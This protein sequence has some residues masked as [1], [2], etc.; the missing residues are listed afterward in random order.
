MTTSLLI[1]PST[2]TLWQPEITTN[3]VKFN[4]KLGF[5]PLKRGPLFASSAPISS[6]TVSSESSK[7]E[8]ELEFL[9][10]KEGDP[11]QRVRVASGEKVLRNIMLDN[12]I[13]LYAT[14]GK[15]MNCGGGGT[16]GTCIVEILDGKDL[17]SERTNAELRH[18]KKKPESWRLACQTIVGN[19]ENYGKKIRGKTV[20]TKRQKMRQTIQS[21]ESCSPKDAS[22]EE[23]MTELPCFSS[24]S[25]DLSL[26]TKTSW[27]NSQTLTAYNPEKPLQGLEE[28]PNQENKD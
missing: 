2:T 8:I 20:F 10:P 1:P 16:C 4:S 18:L 22:M 17:L 5:T 7:P 21:H 9:G 27:I 6:D 19:K 12:T 23:E 3:K 28:A 26:F 13:E 11:V 15:L 24:N 25:K 14:Y